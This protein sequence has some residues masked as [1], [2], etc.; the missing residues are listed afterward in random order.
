MKMTLRTNSDTYTRI[1]RG[2]ERFGDDYRHC[3]NKTHYLIMSAKLKDKNH[4]EFLMRE[5]WSL[6]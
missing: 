6:E 2:I 3:Y 5:V 1:I 4:V